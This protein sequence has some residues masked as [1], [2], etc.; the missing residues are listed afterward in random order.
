[1]DPWYSVNLGDGVTA[2]AVS[3]EVEARFLQVHQ[4]AGKPADMAVFTRFE[5]DGR[6]QCDVV[7][8]F[9]PAAREVA[10]A[11]DAQPCNKPEQAGLIL[12]AGDEQAWSM[13]FPDTE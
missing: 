7:A 5:S 9:S 8:F 2:P 1:M 6:L 11:F 10:K 4:A 13:L 3:N 12:L